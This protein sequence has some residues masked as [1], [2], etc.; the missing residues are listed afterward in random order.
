[1]FSVNNKIKLRDF[2][3][4]IGVLS[5]FAL[6]GCNNSDK[7]GKSINEKAPPVAGKPLNETDSQFAGKYVNEKDSKVSIELKSDGTFFFENGGKPLKG[8][9]SIEGKRFK[10]KFDTGESDEQKFE[11]KTIITREGVR[12]TKQ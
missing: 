2:I 7:A 6:S 9:Y 1:M 8:K 3:P 11:G 5:I 4:I 12:Y 10:F